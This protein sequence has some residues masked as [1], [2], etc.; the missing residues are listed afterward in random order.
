MQRQ[1]KEADIPFFNDDGN[2]EESSSSD[3]TSNDSDVSSCQRHR[4]G[5]NDKSLEFEKQES[6]ASL[7]GDKIVDR[8]EANDTESSMQSNV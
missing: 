7:A 6:Q 1:A 5:K 8:L 4:E 3:S 2:N